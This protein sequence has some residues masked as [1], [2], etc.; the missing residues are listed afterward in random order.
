MLSL[1][2]LERAAAAT[3]RRCVGLRVDR[4]A[5]H[6][7]SGVL[8]VLSGRPEAD[9]TDGEPPAPRVK[10]RLVLDA[11]PALARIGELAGREAQGGPGP[12][13]EEG[14]APPPAPR[15]APPPF[16]Q[17]LRAHLAGARCAGAALLG[18]DRQLALR[19]ATREGER[20]LLLSLLGP[21]TNLWLL[22]AEGRV[23]A[24]LR[25]PEATRR[26][27]TRGTTW[28]APSSQPPRA[29][30]DRFAH[31]PDDALLE[32]IETRYAAQEE[33]TGIEALARRL[34][35][36]L[37]RELRALAKRAERLEEAT[38]EAE[39]ARDLARHGELLKGVLSR[40]PPRAREVEVEDPSTGERVHIELDPK[41]SP[42]GNLEQIF[43][44][45][46]RARSQEER[47]RAERAALEVRRSAVT[48]QRERLAALASAPDATP[49]GIAALAHEPPLRDLL[50]R[51]ARQAPPAER[52]RGMRKPPFAEL[53][54]ALR[55]R[56]YRSA[57]GLE[58]WVG[59]S[60]EG[61]DHLSTRLARGNDLFFHVDGGSGS[62]VVLRLGA[63]DHAPQESLLDA[64]ELA[65]HFSKRRGAPATD[66]IVAP[67][68][69]VRKPRGAKPGLVEVRGGRVVRLRRDPERLARVLATRA[70]GE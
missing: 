14:G 44:R 6:G 57:D 3:T 23:E 22:D 31:V 53:A 32:A 64:C 12:E 42:A 29:G 37:E 11:T 50:R 63:L 16:V 60:D 27:M 67:A 13:G 2:E 61:N 68:K 51:T 1:C 66:V 65:A 7:D 30:E 10:R 56:V 70:E 18:G 43:R 5:A 19:L 17:Y 33:S 55:P 35:T 59:R 28:R 52:W 24:S 54:P 25:P 36:A 38:H 4:I 46:R 8:L 20:T 41:L 48:A 62:H 58:I 15:V 39:A 40:V 45:H 21:R 26:E 9:V 49:A 47:A 34:A 69:D